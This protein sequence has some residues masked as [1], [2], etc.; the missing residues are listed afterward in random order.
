MNLRFIRP[1]DRRRSGGNGT[2]PGTRPEWAD[3]VPAFFRSE[4]F[5]EDLAQGDPGAVLRLERGAQFG[6]LPAN[7]VRHEEG[8]AAQSFLL[9][10]HRLVGGWAGTVRPGP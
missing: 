4:A 3:T 8:R 6:L 7:P 2:S 1:E 10:L 5:A 9:V